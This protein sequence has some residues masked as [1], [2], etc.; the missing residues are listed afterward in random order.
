MLDQCLST[1]LGRKHS[2]CRF[3]RDKIRKAS[4]ES[5]QSI[6]AHG[7]EPIMLVRL[8]NPTGV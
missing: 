7:W 2:I 4:V 8:S 1:I 5:H 3:C 6:Q